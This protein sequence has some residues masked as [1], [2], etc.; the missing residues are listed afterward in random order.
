[1]AFDSYEEKSIKDGARQSRFT[2]SSVHLSAIHGKTPVPPEQLD[3]FWSSSQNND[4]FQEYFRKRF[5]LSAV[6][7]KHNVVLSGMPI[8]GNQ[9]SAVSISEG[10]TVL[11]ESLICNIEE[12]AQRLIKH[13]H[14][15]S[16]TK[17]YTITH[18]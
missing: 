7:N 1:M 16:L 5:T 9:V 3:K 15:S 17:N 12:A 10:Q 4:S 18:N 13:I 2:Q 8:N 14:W 6:K 11:I